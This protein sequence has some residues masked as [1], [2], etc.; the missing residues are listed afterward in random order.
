[1]LTFIRSLKVWGAYKKGVVYTQSPIT[2]SSNLCSKRFIFKYC[3]FEVNNVEMLFSGVFVV[4]ISLILILV[5][6]LLIL[7][8]IFVET[9]IQNI[10]QG[11]PF[12]MEWT[13][14]LHVSPNSFPVLLKNLH[15]S[16]ETHSNFQINY[17]SFI[18]LW[19]CQCICI[20][21]YI[22]VG[23][24]MSIVLS[25]PWSHVSKVTHKYASTQ[26]Q[27]AYIKT[28]LCYIF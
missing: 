21:H 22:F 12:M 27:I 8:I 14:H 20:C 5:T 24:I 23:H 18:Y 9:F 3:P 25:S 10:I 13:Q 15:F 11:S 28:Q 1:M 26:I 19:F 4:D 17:S 7:I 16:P 6:T 2:G